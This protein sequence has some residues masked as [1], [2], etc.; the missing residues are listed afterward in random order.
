MGDAYRLVFDA[1]ARPYALTAIASGWALL[2]LAGLAWWLFRR[3]GVL[4]R[5]DWMTVGVLGLGLF[6]CTTE[7]CREV[8]ASR[9]C[10][11]ASQGALGEVVEG[12]VEELASMSREGKPC[13]QFRVGPQAFRLEESEGG[14]HF[15]RT[16]VHGGPLRPGLPVRIRHVGGRIMKLEVAE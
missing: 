16:A 3:P 4:H 7:S 15:H 5:R 2:L 14:C 12:Q 8:A 10:T 11:L 13:E 6:I 9:E 1:G